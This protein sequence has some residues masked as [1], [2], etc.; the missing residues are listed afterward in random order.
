[1]LKRIITAVVCLALF[2][3]VLVFSGTTVG[4]YI[5]ISV[6]GLLSLVAMY[7][8][9]GCFGLKKRIFVA[10]PSYFLA[11][12]ATLITVFFLESEHYVAYL[13]CAGFL[14]MF[15]VLASS[16]FNTGIV[17]FSQAASVVATAFYIICGFFSIIFLRYSEMGMY[18]YWLVF[19]GAWATDT[20][21]YFVGVLCGKH[22][23]IPEVSP[24]KTVEGAIGGVLGCVIGYLIFGL[25]MDKFCSLTV[26]Y[27]A[28]IVSAVIIAVISQL[29]DL[30]ASYIKREH[31]IKD[32]GNIFPGHGGVMDRFDSIIAVAPVI[33][34]I[35]MIFGVKLLS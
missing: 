7:E 25:C 15:S 8:I 23:L 35:T 18:L 27:T 34:G 3:P 14:F 31:D 21:A 6:L 24:K 1:M 19:I 10:A 5:F 20:G 22:K 17:R 16:M 9:C 33:L 29:G 2:I 4:K 11:I 13:L 26:N 30:I 32:Y 28:L 12:V